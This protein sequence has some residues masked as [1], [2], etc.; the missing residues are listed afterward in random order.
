MEAAGAGFR[1]VAR[2]ELEAVQAMAARIWWACYRGM[3]SDEQI[4]RMLAWMYDPARVLAEMDAGVRWEWLEVLG[5]P[6]GYLAWEPDGEGAHLHKL[7]LERPWHGQG[8]GQRMLEH[9]ARQARACGC[10][11]IELRVNRRN[12]RALRAYRRA[13][14]EHVADDVRDIG[15]GFVMDDH[16]LRLTLDD[17]R[18]VP[19]DPAV[20]M[21]PAPH[22]PGA[23]GLP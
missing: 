10:R 21:A 22:P 19:S 8:L 3:V 2:H 15:D 14:F 4:G 7:Y 16:I 13:G 18:P 9:V 6:R 11:R 20:P 5:V 23:P 12:D 1:P 17:A